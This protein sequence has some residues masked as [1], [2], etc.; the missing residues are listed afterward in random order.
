MIGARLLEKAAQSFKGPDYRLDPDVPLSG[1]L[2]FS[3][4]RGAALL[5]CL[6]RGVVFSLNPRKLV[7]LGPGVVLRNRRMIRFGHSVTLGRGVVIDG[8]S[9]HGVELGDNVKVGSYSIIEA[10]SVITHIGEGC[11][12]G[13]R[14]AIGE[15]SYIGAVGGVWIGEDVIMGQRVGF[16]SEDHVFQ[17][18]DV[19]I[20]EQG[21]TRKGITI[22]NDCWIGANVTF[23]DGAHV[24]QGCVIGAGAVV[25]GEIP[26]FSVAVGVP[27]RVIKSRRTEK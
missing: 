13:A 11:R 25:K 6:L 8:L 26:P 2:N 1:L 5:R 16:H 27:A 7:F 4:R 15:H 24:G 9:K 22:E 21:V 10:T 20:R 18:T 23:L 12:M 17:R 19:P 3:L 14:S